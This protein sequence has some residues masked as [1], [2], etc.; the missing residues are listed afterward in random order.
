VFK[1]TT[2][3]NLIQVNPLRSARPTMVRN[4]GGGNNAKRQGRKYAVEDKKHRL[5]LSADPAELYGL[6]NRIYGNGMC[7]AVT[8]EGVEFLCHIRNKFRGRSKRDNMVAI[9]CWILMG[10][11]VWSS[12]FSG[13]RSGK[14]PEADLLEVYTSAECEELRS[15]GAIP[16]NVE[17][18]VAGAFRHTDDGFEFGDGHD[19]PQKAGICDEGAEAGAGAGAGAECAVKSAN[20]GINIDD[21]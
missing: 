20:I 11:R 19:A 5:R 10:A 4:S 7:Q 12:A 3:H 9:N 17:A 6:V 16:P 18:H 21:I 14:R 2:L 8:L 15:R 13:T 1:L